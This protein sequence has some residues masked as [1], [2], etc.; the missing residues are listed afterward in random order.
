MAAISDGDTTKR[1]F[2]VSVSFLALV[3]LLPL[4]VVIALLVV[5]D[6]GLP[7]FYRQE[8][9]GLHGRH[10]R[11]IK[12]RT[13]VRGADRIAG[14]VSA[15]GDPRV[16]RAGRVLRRCYLDELPQL[17]NVLRGDMSLV[18]PRPE[19]PEFV[20]LYTP[21]ERKVLSVRAGLAGPSTLAFMDEAELLAG[22]PDSLALYANE[23]L[24]ARVGADL[25]YLEKKSMRYDI[26]LLFSQAWAIVRR[27]V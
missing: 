16:T 23:I 11:I 8:R 10:F 20:E 1:L 25:T 26:R 15:T 22:A 6:S 3:V 2:D 27:L 19:T 9:V 5:L 21:E 18:G 14:N 17:F 7:V 4:F 24:H 13:M 12:F